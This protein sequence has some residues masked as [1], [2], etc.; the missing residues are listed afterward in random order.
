MP[1]AAESGAV[2][3]PEC[4]GERGRGLVMETCSVPGASSP[5]LPV[6]CRGRSVSRVTSS[7]R[8]GGLAAAACIL[9]AVSLAVLEP[10]GP[11]WHSWTA[12]RVEKTL[13]PG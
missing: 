10:G 9:P 5:R 2:C 1:P 7:L 13:F 6:F 8:G 12:S 11:R 3:G 4:S